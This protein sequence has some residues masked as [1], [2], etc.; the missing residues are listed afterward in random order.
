M[1]MVSKRSKTKETKS[2]SDIKLERIELR[3]TPRQKA[4][5][6]RAAELSGR[7]LRAFIVTVMDDAAARAVRDHEVLMLSKKDSV[8]F[9][10]A[11]LQPAASNQNLKSAARRYKKG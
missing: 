3:V 4:L 1:N 2:T 10:T 5:Y 9:V 7:S 6:A 8:A 11:L